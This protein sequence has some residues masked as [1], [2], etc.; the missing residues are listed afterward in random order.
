[1]ATKR[2][3]RGATMKQPMI[4]FLEHNMVLGATGAGKGVLTNARM[5]FF[6]NNGMKVVWLGSK[7]DEYEDL[8]NHPRLYKTMR[9]DRFMAVINKC[10]APKRGFVDTM[11]IVDEA[12][13]WKW[14]G[15]NGLEMI[16]NSGRSY[17]IELWV[18]SQFPTHMA[19]TVRANCRNRYVFTLDEPSA[20]DWVKKCLGTK[21]GE[22][23]ELPLGR[24]IGKRGLGSFFYGTA[25]YGEPGTS[26]WV[27]VQ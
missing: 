2:K 20:I 14:K 21:F 6:L 22:C 25:W 4:K 7:L 10:R 23:S 19:P 24:Y 11:A 13:N 3:F 5:R 16:P 1:M 17:G 27:G 12:W 18:Q 9:Q 26:S 15:V 8:P